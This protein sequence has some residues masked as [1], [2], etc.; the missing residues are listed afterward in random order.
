MVI[1]YLYMFAYTLLYIQR[2]CELFENLLKIDL[3]LF[4][5]RI[6]LGKLTPFST[7]VPPPTHTIPYICKL[8]VL[9][10]AAKMIFI[11]YY[12]IIQISGL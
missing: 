4:L 7:H 1:V 6:L 2:K 9:D 5:F 3:D 8:S 10:Y 11:I 12:I